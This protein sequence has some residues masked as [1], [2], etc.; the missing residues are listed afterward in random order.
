MFILGIIF[1]GQFKSSTYPKDTVFYCVVVLS[2]AAFEVFGSSNP[3]T[4]HYFQ[5]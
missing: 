2:F 3:K 4:N 1:I 5:K